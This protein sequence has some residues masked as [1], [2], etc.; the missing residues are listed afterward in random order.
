MRNGASGG[1]DAAA[2]VGVRSYNS[3]DVLLSTEEERSGV[4]ESESGLALSNWRRSSRREA[5]KARGCGR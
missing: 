4:A 1:P 5:V 2:A 3:I